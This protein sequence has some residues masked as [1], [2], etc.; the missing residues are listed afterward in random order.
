MKLL[1]SLFVVIL[2]QNWASAFTEL[3]PDFF[4][5]VLLR[6]KRETTVDSEGRV[7]STDLCNEDQYQE[8]L[9]DWDVCYTNAI[10]K[11]LDEYVWDGSDQ[12]IERA[13]CNKY[14]D[15]AKCVSD[16]GPQGLKCY[17]SEESQNRK[18]RVLYSYHQEI[19]VNGTSEEGKQFI[20]SCVAFA[21]FKNDYIKY[22]TG[23][24]RCC[25]FDQFENKYKEWSNCLDE[26]LLKVEQRRKLAYSIGGT[27]GR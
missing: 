24:P 19:T 13:T 10:T 25:S 27:A 21:N 23:C 3:E 16:G 11:F 20:N 17:D 18:L 7:I 9:S 4:S 1:L 12:E 26:T 14:L 6:T 8:F 22:R 5:E 15:Q 2:S